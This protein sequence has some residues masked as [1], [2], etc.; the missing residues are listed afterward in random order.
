MSLINLPKFNDLT[1]TLEQTELKL[2]A[3]QVHGLMTGVL[4]GSFDKNSDWQ[5]LV[6]GEKLTD[7]TEDM[8]QLLYEGTA[9][10]LSDFLFEFTIVLPDDD[11]ELPVRAE[12]LTVWCQGY[13]TG[14]KV[15][16]VPIANR[17]PSDLTEAIDD[18]IEIAKMN[19]QQVESSEEDEEAYAE[20]VEYVRMAVILIFQ[21]SH[22]DMFANGATDASR[23]H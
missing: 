6:M 17:E 2:H 7:E 9:K 21:E 4:S 14:L 16:G 1:I 20:L 8:M 19:Y 15:A 13:V 11:V 3:S 22:V 12:A 10:Q 23:L 5:Q 18:L